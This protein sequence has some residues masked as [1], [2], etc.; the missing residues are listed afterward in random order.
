MIEQKFIKYAT[1]FHKYH[2][3]NNI[4]RANIYA[5]KLHLIKL[6]LMRNNSCNEFLDNIMFC[7]IDMARIWACGMCIDLNYRKDDA[8]EILKN[9]SKSK[10]EIICRDAKMSLNVRR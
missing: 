9:L 2:Q 6:E 5:K 8:I 4:S 7:E 10:D 1:C 3:E